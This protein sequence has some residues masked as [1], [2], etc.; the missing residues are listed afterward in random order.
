MDDHRLLLELGQ[1]AEIFLDVGIEQL[2]IEG[3]KLLLRQN[4]LDFLPAEGVGS[5][6]RQT[7]F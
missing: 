6:E 5:D 2:D 4:I 7:V 1:L 3:R